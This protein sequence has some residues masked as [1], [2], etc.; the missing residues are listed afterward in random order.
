MLLVSP[1][2]REFFNVAFV[3]DTVAFWVI[4]VHTF[5]PLGTQ[6]HYMQIK[7]TTYTFLLCVMDVRMQQNYSSLEHREKALY[8]GIV[9]YITYFFVGEV[10]DPFERFMKGSNHYPQVYV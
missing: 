8:H 1:L 3:L 9:S 5:V 2:E 10:K 7:T 4:W 6:L